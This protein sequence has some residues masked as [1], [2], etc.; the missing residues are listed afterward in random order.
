MSDLNALIIFAK[1]VEAGSFSE[2]ARRLSMPVS[3]V[4]RRVADLEDQLGVRLMERS[5]RSLRLT[6][7]GSEVLGQAQRGVEVSDAVK[8]IVSNRLS[9]VYGLLRISAPPSISESLLIPIITPFQTAHPNVRVQVLVTDRHVD[10]LAEGVDL[11]FRIGDQ[12]DSALISKRILRYRHRLVASPAYLQGRPPVRTPSD[13]LAHKIH[14]FS[15]WRPQ[16]SWTF[17]SGNATETISFEPVLS[18]NDYAGL[19]AALVRGAGIGDLPPVVLPHLVKDGTLVEVMQDWRFRAMDVNLVHMGH[20]HVRRV[21]RVFKD[22]AAQTAP[23][24][25]ED[26]PV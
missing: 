25:F 21:V 6:D 5:T 20:R 22:F 7:I 19:A 8:G 4:S 26:L 1:V 11:V 17:V 24:L 23:R 14:A 10:P 16:N 12:K 13:L 2:A 15:F 3:T 18:M 9:E